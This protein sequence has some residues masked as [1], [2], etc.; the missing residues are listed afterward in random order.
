MSAQVPNRGF[1][2]LVGDRREPA[3]AR[4]RERRQD[5]DAAEQP[6]SGPRAAP[7]TS[8]RCPRA[9]RDRSASCGR[10]DGSP[11]VSQ[12]AGSATE[13]TAQGGRQRRRPAVAEAAHL[14]RQVGEARPVLDVAEGELPAGSRVA[15]AAESPSIGKYGGDEIWK[16][17]PQRAPS[18]GWPVSC[19]PSDRTRRRVVD[20]RTGQE[21]RRPIDPGHARR[22]EPRERRGVADAT[23]AGDLGA[24][25]RGSL[26]VTVAV[27]GRE[28]KAPCPASSLARVSARRPGPRTRAPSRC[29]R[30]AAAAPSR[31]PAARSEAGRPIHV[32]SP[33]GSPSAP[34]EVGPGVEP[35]DRVG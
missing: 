29:P 17:E 11:G 3:V 9:S 32:L 21:R 1:D 33:S 2:L 31:R 18:S 19:G 35:G 6:S 12:D 34:P 25:I 22:V 10:S 16:P 20:R 14:V 7:S 24:W 23:G 13:H 30:R 8:A 15:E 27:G 26:N 5:V 28:R 4:G